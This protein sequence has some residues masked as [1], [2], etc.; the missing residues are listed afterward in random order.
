MDWNAKGVFDK[1]MKFIIENKVS[2]NK[3]ADGHILCCET[4]QEKSTEGAGKLVV[5]RTNTL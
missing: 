5:T 3:N 1:M 2:Y 4:F